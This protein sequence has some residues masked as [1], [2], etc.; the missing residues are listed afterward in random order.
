MPELTG[1]AGPLLL[2]EQ[3]MMEELFGTEDDTPE[4]SKV[5][6][7][8]PTREQTLWEGDGSRSPIRFL[9]TDTPAKSVLPSAAKK[10]FSSPLQEEGD[11][12]KREPG[13]PG[14]AM[15][16]GKVRRVSPEKHQ[17]RENG[18]AREGSRWGPPK[19]LTIPKIPKKTPVPLLS[20]HTKP[21]S[22]KGSRQDRPSVIHTSSSSHRSSSSSHRASHQST[23]SS[24]SSSHHRS[25]KEPTSSHRSATSSHR[26]EHSSSSSSTSSSK[27]RR[28]SAT[29]SKTGHSA[30]SSSHGLTKKVVG[31][32][33]RRVVKSVVTQVTPLAAAPPIVPGV[34]REPQ[35]VAGCL[36]TL[37]QIV[38][39]L[40]LDTEESVP[41]LAEW[42][43]VPAHLITPVKA[44]LLLDSTPWPNLSTGLTPLF[45][46][47][48]SQLAT[49][50]PPQMSDREIRAQ[51]LPSTRRAMYVD[52]G[53]EV[54]V[55]SE[56]ARLEVT[57]LTKLS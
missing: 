51:P 26:Q 4:I 57:S 30:Q 48:A 47:A 7:I 37:G 5:T 54:G 33:T 12:R 24:S 8:S 34:A 56:A 13:P 3:E 11:K 40:G 46:T 31:E 18:A 44:N 10:L 19:D 52:L 9:A 6:H 43:T 53:I 14:G 42:P 35:P 2:L 41:H 55:W 50:Q 15:D 39:N 27:H 21:V 17:E 45:S 36:D 29:D 1:E 20:L 22:S 16:K 28:S 49:R 23:G 32:D 25:M 38:D